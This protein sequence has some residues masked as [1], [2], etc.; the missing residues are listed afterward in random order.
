M[1]YYAHALERSSLTNFWRTAPNRHRRSPKLFCFP[2][3]R[4]DAW[5]SIAG[6][7]E[8]EMEQSRLEVTEEP[9]VHSYVAGY[10]G[11]IFATRK[12]S[13]TTPSRKRTSTSGNTG[14]P[15]KCIF[16]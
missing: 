4:Y 15:I 5:L 12:S 10:L 2:G 13:S 1:L 6:L 8:M 11:Q 16:N 9:M 14:F 3:C 7:V